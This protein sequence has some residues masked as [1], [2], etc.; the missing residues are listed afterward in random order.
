MRSRDVSASSSVPTHTHVPLYRSIFEHK[1][2]RLILLRIDSM[3]AL[4]AL[5]APEKMLN[6][7][8][9]RSHS[10][11]LLHLPQLLCTRDVISVCIRRT[12]CGS[13]K[14]M[15]DGLRHTQMHLCPIQNR[16]ANKI[17]LHKIQLFLNPSLYPSVNRCFPPLFQT[18]V[19]TIA[20][21]SRPGILYPNAGPYT[22]TA[23][24]R[25]NMLSRNDV[26][27]RRKK[28]SLQKCAR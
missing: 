21:K 26:K 27:E 9:H 22:V 4:L 10:Y 13:R 15:I 5:T 17:M 19:Q 3:D 6:A 12:K 28:K 8:K 23:S 7:H 16:K 25:K 24:S 18:P 20:I 2:W 1:C 11:S 14:R